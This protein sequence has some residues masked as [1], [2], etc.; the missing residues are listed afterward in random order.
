MQVFQNF[1]EEKD[2]DD[3][4]DEKN[5]LNSKGMCLACVCDAWVTLARV[6]SVHC[7]RSRFALAVRALSRRVCRM[8]RGQ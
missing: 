6:T 5:A 7:R 2:G 8:A 1:D 3:V 4:Q